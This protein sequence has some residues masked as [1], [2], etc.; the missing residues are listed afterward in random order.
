MTPRSSA[1][2]SAVAVSAYWVMQYDSAVLWIYR[3]GRMVLFS[4]CALATA[5]SRREHFLAR[6]PAFASVSSWSDVSPTCGRPARMATVAG[7]TP[8]PRMM[9]STPLRSATR[10]R[11]CGAARCVDTPMRDNYTDEADETSSA[12][13]LCCCTADGGLFLWIAIA[14]AYVTFWWQPCL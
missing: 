14:Q 6:G 8:R 4:T 12:S 7:T 5:R 10:K 13:S 9:S 11:D 3:S 2:V 1:R